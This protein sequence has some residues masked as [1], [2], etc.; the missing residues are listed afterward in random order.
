MKRRILYGL[1]I[2]IGTMMNSFGPLNINAESTEN[3]EMFVVGQTEDGRQIYASTTRETLEE[4]LLNPYA[5]GNSQGYYQWQQYST[6]I[7]KLDNDTYVYCSEPDEAFPTGHWYGHGVKLNNKN[8]DALLTWGFP[9]NQGG[10]HELSDTEAY[11]RTFV[12]LNAYLGNFTRSTVESYGDSYVNML[13]QKADAQDLPSVNVSLQEP[14]SLIA[15]H[16]QI[17]NRLET[18]LYHVSGDTGVFWLEDLPSDFY[19]VGEDN[20]TYHTLS[21]GGKFRIVTDNINY[22][23]KINFKIKAKLN[24][25]TTTRYTSTGVQKIMTLQNEE[26][27]KELASKAEF[28]AVLGKYS[29]YKNIV[30]NA[31]VPVNHDKTTVTL[32]VWNNDKSYDTTH[33]IKQDGTSETYEVPMGTYFYEETHYDASMIPTN[34]ATGSFNV[35]ANKTLVIT[36]D[37]NTATGTLAIEKIVKQ[38]GAVPV[39]FDLSQIT[40]QITDD[41]TTFDYSLTRNLDSD[42]KLVI[43]NLPIGWYT[44]KEIAVPLG[45]DKN[46]T[47]FRIYVDNEAKNKTA[48]VKIENQTTVGHL[49]I[50]KELHNTTNDSGNKNYYPTQ[51]L[52]Q[53]KINIK[54]LETT[55]TYN[56][57][58]YLNAQGE[59]EIKNLPIGKYEV[60]EISVPDDMTINS[61]IF[62][63]EVKNSATENIVLVKI[64]NNLLPARVRIGKRDNNDSYVAN[65]RFIGGSSLLKNESGQPTV[66]TYDMMKNT[67]VLAPSGQEPTADGKYYYRVDESTKLFDLTTDSTGKALSEWFLYG[68]KTI[69][70]QEVAANNYLMLNKTV[71]SITLKPETEI[72]VE[73]TNIIKDNLQIQ[74][75]KTDELNNFVAWYFPIYRIETNGAETYMETIVTNNLT[76]IGRSSILQAIDIDIQNQPYNIPYKICE[77]PHPL[78]QPQNCQQVTKM[79][80]NN[81]NIITVSMVNT[82]KEINYVL[83]K[84]AETNPYNLQADD[85]TFEIF[86]QQTKQI[87]ATGKV[88]NKLVQFSAIRVDEILNNENLYYREVAA[89]DAFEIDPESYAVPTLTE[90]Y[91]E[92]YISGSA[93]YLREVTHPL[94]NK[95]KTPKISTTATTGEHGK[96]VKMNANI[97][98]IDVIAYEHLIPNYE[99]E[100]VGII[101]EKSTEQPLLINDNQVTATITFIPNEA[102]GTISVPFHFNSST[103]IHG[104][105]LVVFEYLYHNETEIVN[106]TDINDLGQTVYV[107]DKLVQTGHN[108][109]RLLLSFCMIALSILLYT[110][111][112]STH[113]LAK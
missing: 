103:L 68:Y 18:D 104:Q 13:L 3:I 77:Q 57:D 107:Q 46:D 11:V 78:Y 49:K 109:E 23:G 94:I 91:L 25:K 35:E 98:L 75:N 95:L 74:V 81:G 21:I 44:I 4:A 32:R 71:K 63:V 82:F 43:Q 12:A 30:Q 62:T 90:K 108:D 40:V 42:G 86:D 26:I 79:N 24:Q 7:I 100:V 20:Q 105:E 56:K 67:E 6:P 97:E 84:V 34:T 54:T 99:Y 101:M 22:T 72:Y 110:F 69:Y 17:T 73:F 88:K 5:T 59:L 31:V 45:M 51:F 16:N 83:P 15:T 14:D 89:P 53:I 66:W 52:N 111:K 55:F 50:I 96:E 8:V 33:T 113:N 106:H 64:A 76:G 87:Y 1:L 112:K 65:T 19:L 28:K 38:Q 9:N 58:F 85:A 29:F 10:Q 27:T 37:N 61:N 102:N 70:V 93:I 48:L 36:V 80:A 39:T 41:M 60:T 47:V 2:I 92:Q